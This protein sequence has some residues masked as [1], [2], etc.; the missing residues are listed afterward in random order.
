MGVAGIGFEDA[1]IETRRGPRR[2]LVMYPHARVLVGRERL[3]ALEARGEVSPIDEA[4]A[5]RLAATKTS[6]PYRVVIF[7]G[8]NPQ[9]PE[10]NWR[11]DSGLDLGETRR[12]SLLLAASQLATWRRMLEHGVWLMVHTDLGA[13][14][15]PLRAGARE[16]ISDPIR[17]EGVDPAIAEIDEWILQHLIFFSSGSCETALTQT[18]PD[19]L[20]LVEMRAERLESFAETLRARAEAPRPSLRV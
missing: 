10:S 1:L 7:Q 9:E 4:V 8:R 3:Q 2:A 11:L 14:A 13:S 17:R 12:L 19:K 20:P 5:A 18:L 15:A 16:L 6:D